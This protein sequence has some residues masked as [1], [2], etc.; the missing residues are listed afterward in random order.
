MTDEEMEALLNAAGYTLH[1]SQL[2][3]WWIVDTSS[4]YADA[5]GEQHIKRGYKAWIPN[6]I[7]TDKHTAF[8]TWI[9]QTD[10][11]FI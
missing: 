6:E 10:G 2:F 5:N 1:Q 3:G 11:I 7:T 9:T 8:N 4:V